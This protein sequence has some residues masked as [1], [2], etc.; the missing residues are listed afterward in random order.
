MKEHVAPLLPQVAYACSSQ[1]SI[2]TQCDGESDCGNIW[3]HSLPCVRRGVAPVMLMA[4][5]LRVIPAL[6]DDG[7]PFG[8]EMTLDV[9]SPARLQA[10]ARLP[11]IGDVGEAVLELWC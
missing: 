8:L 3:F 5:V 11:S 2:Q 1:I 10:D 7:F 4:S 6:A 9:G